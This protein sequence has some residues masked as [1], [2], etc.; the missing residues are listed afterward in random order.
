MLVWEHKLQSYARAVQRDL[1]V[2]QRQS[3]HP[4]LLDQDLLCPPSL[5]FVRLFYHVQIYLRCDQYGQ[6]D[7]FR[8]Q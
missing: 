8:F 2:P 4:S 7:S 3:F 1:A 5:L 6:K